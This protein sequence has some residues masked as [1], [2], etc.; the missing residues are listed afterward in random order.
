MRRYL[1]PLIVSGVVAGLAV[2]LATVASAAPAR[3][4]A[5][6]RLEPT[7]VRLLTGDSVRLGT[8]AG[9]PEVSV[10]PAQRRGI[11]GRFQ[12]VSFG[13]DSYV[14]PAVA[15]PFL[16]GLLDPSLFDVT[17]LA[18][19]EHARRI[20]VTINTAKGA[21]V[22]IPGLVV[23]SR[24]SRITRG[25]LT[26]GG[27]AAWRTALTAACRRA[28]RPGGSVPATLFGGMRH[29]TLT[30]AVTP[31]VPH[32]QMYTLKLKVL[33]AAG[34]PAAGGDIGVINTDDARRYTAIAFYQHGSARI[35]VPAGHY[36]AI[37]DVGAFNRRTST[38]TDRIIPIADFAV[39]SNDQTLTL[40]ARTATSRVAAHTPRRA[41]FHQSMSMEFDRETKFG[42]LS[43][44][45]D[46][47]GGGFSV[48]VA[49]TPRTH[50]GSLQWLTGWSRTGKAPKTGLYSY[51]LS[52]A[53]NGRVSPHQS[54]TV[55]PFQLAT[56]HA[57]YY[58]DRRRQPHSMFMRMAIYP[59]QFIG[60]GTYTNLTT[61]VVRTEYIYGDASA[62]WYDEFVA[63]STWRVPFGGDMTDGARRYLPGAQRRVDW[64]RGPLDP[65]TPVQTNG[66]QQAFTCMACRTVHRM[67]IGL[68]PT[69]DSTPGH[70]GYVTATRHKHGMHFA[71]YR[72]QKLLDRR[73][74]AVLTVPALTGRYRL[75]MT[76]NR[77]AD[78]ARAST[79]T[80][81]DLTF[82]SAAGTGAP[83]PDG[84]GCG[85]RSPHVC[86]V[87]PLLHAR[88]P[89][90]TT[91]SDRLPVGRSSFVLT[92]APIQGA[93]HARIT[94]ASF[95]TRLP[96]GR[97]RPAAMH[98][99]GNGRYRV[100]LINPRSAL[101]K[102]VAIRVA[103]RDAA[104][105]SITQ[106]TRAAYFV[107]RR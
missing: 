64:D 71:L 66:E 88:V 51:D 55:A 62:I 90:P 67:S 103:G 61:P 21:H 22:R 106:T 3:P 59:F 40:D 82:R 93:R 9:R 4:A 70:V 30:G 72:G 73:D 25:Y 102:S 65:S 99:L 28:L 32:F 60:F 81:T 56:V 54:H 35:S 83:L 29:L 34:R 19:L 57:R 107:G 2:P 92:L 17:A 85:I 16:G 8:A 76:T 10:V 20:P 58:S 14:V 37:T 13:Q 69:S 27:A 33:N 75:H 11:T 15:Q 84:W 48:R 53:D 68:Y 18:R 100:T 23:A 52:F 104:G 77:A 5:S 78:G 1:M 38:F 39:T 41:P 95:Q 94:A 96:G 63:K 105:D 89:L 42:A 50:F 44:G 101:G 6:H 74:G 24:S 26:L 36:S 46:F 47:D 7:V 12:T 43:F 31:P 45:W 98:R 49:P 79:A 80:I 86:T 87:L 91:L 97:F